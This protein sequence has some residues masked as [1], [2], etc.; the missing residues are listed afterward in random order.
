MRFVRTLLTMLALVAIVPTARARAA[1][2]PDCAGKVEI[3]AARIVRTEQNGVLVMSDGRAIHLE[4]IRIPNSRADR[5]PATLQVQA[6]TAL[7]QMANDNTLILT[8][9]EP[10]EDRYDR[11]RAQAFSGA[12]W[13]QIALL[14]RGLARVSIA[15]DR[16]ECAAVLYDAE[17]Q[18]RT[19]RAGLWTL[20]AY[21]VR[22]TQSVAGDV[23]TFQIVEG[24]VTGADVLNGVMTLSFGIGLRGEFHATIASDDMAN[25]RMIGVNPKGYAGKTLRVRGIVQNDNGPMIEIANP[26]QVELVQ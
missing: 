6:L 20:P 13:I 10:K 11:I 14:K 25:F 17:K 1:D 18:A 3:S 4:G 26:M 21:A 7:S 15:P 24:K 16:I 9:V 5:A 8:A 2:M 12:D 23:G 22:T 19:L